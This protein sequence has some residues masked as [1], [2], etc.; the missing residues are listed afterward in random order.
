[1][2]IS[3]S[4]RTLNPRSSFCLAISVVL[5]NGNALMVGFA[6]KKTVNGNK[7]QTKMRQPSTTKPIC[8]CVSALA[9]SILP[10]VV[11]DEFE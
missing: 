4:I 8:T 7:E 3:T 10:G 9:S 11:A 1:M 5:L 2:K 6:I